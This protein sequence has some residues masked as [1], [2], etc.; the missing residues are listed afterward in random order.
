MK[1]TENSVQPS[2]CLYV[3]NT[4]TWK[5]PL[6]GESVRVGKLGR[7]PKVRDLVGD[8]GAGQVFWWEE[9]TAQA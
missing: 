1:T 5:D 8:P 4:W 6:E 9:E 2:I 7:A 3:S